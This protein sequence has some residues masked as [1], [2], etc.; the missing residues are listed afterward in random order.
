MKPTAVFDLNTSI[1]YDEVKPLITNL[2]GTKPSFTFSI[3]E[4]DKSKPRVSGN[5]WV[6]IPD[7]TSDAPVFTGEVRLTIDY[8]RIVDEP[9]YSRYLVNPTWKELL[10]EL[11]HMMVDNDAEDSFLFL[12][13]FRFSKPVMDVNYY[14][15]V[16]GS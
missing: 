1:K 3:M 8:W 10:T 2:I 16:F 15:V 7:L 5:W 6:M 4:D 13:D 12:E 9:V 11:N 14:K